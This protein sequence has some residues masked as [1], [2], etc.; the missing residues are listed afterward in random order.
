MSLACQ[1]YR[2]TRRFYAPSSGSSDPCP[3]PAFTQAEEFFAE[4]I[5]IADRYTID[6]YVSVRLS[7]LCNHHDP[8]TSH[9]VWLKMLIIVDVLVGVK[10]Q[11]LCDLTKVSSEIQN[12][13]ALPISYVKSPSNVPN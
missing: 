10:V 3:P 13:N 11:S 4:F 2:L 1:L 7:L 8:D 9:T 6:G 12:P 5:N